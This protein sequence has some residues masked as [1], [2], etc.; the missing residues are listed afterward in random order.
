MATITEAL[1]IALD[2]HGAGRLDEAAVLYGRIL[3]ADPD[4]AQALYLA[5]TLLCQ[6]G[7]FGEALGRLGR[8]LELA[9]GLGGAHLNVAKIHAQRGDWAAAAAPARRAA[10]LAPD[11]AAAWD[12]LGTAERQVGRSDAAIAA[13][14]RA[15]RLA[16]GQPAVAGKL[17]LLLEERGRRHLAGQRNADALADLLGAA[18][19]RP[20]EIDLGFALAGALAGLGRGDEAAALYERLLALGPSESKVLHMLGVVRLVAGRRD[21]GLRGLTRAAVLAPQDPEPCEALTSALQDQDRAAALH[22][23]TRALAAKLAQAPAVPTESVPALPAA[24][25]S[26]DVVSFSLWGRLEAYCAGALENARQVPARLPGWRCRFYH[27]DTV[28]PHILAE[29]AALGAELVAMPAET[30]ARQGMFWRF[31]PSDDP[32]VRRFLVRDCDSRLTARE[33]AAIGDWVASGLPFSVMRDH[34]MHLE[35]M[36]GGMWG[37]TAGVLPPIGPAMDRFTAERSSRWNDQHFLAEWVWPRIAARVLVHDGLHDGLGVP[38]PDAGPGGDVLP[39]EGHVGAKLFH[40]VRLPPLPEPAG[41]DDRAAGPG[42]HGRLVHPASAMQV[43][44]SLDRLGEWLELE[45]ALGAGHL[46]PGDVA[47]DLAAGI[48]A[49]ALAFAHA[50][51]PQGQVLAV[52][53]SP[54]L[55]VCLAATLACNADAPVRFCATPAEA[56]A[57]VPDGR[58]Q[59]LIRASLDQDGAAFAPPVAE[60]VARHRPVLYLRIERD[61]AE[62]LA[63]D[64]LRGLGYRLWWH[65]A[66]VFNPGNRLGCTASPFPGLV[67]VNAL[68]LPPGPDQPPPALVAVDAAS[69]REAS[70]RLTCDG[71]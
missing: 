16:P 46:A 39:D 63:F 34:L 24:G 12:L 9:P 1:T 43:G 58:R 30:T 38:F 61:G 2:L 26:L 14:T 59:R 47:I 29:L 37:G 3:D 23:S 6:Q 19:L 32:A 21:E 53:P 62:T 20:F 8:S 70:W 66:P 35:P 49:H 41:P 36:M 54:G 64:A 25:R 71:R 17:G 28:P 57:A 5:G 48:G 55:S 52:E 42:R 4:N 11:D 27:D 65:I 40:L 69:W 15:H 51:G 44:R 10:V 13:L 60:A 67:T 7:R 22:W 31:L 56:F 33:V 45:A 68:A 18:A 50:V